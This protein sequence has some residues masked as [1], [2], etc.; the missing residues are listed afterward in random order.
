M[1][2]VKPV[3]K[4][5]FICIYTGPSVYGTS[6]ARILEGVAISFSTG[7]PPPRDRTQ[8]SCICRQILYCLVIKEAQ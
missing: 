6:Q 7:S 8:V 1:E 5:M 2:K 4:N 3:T